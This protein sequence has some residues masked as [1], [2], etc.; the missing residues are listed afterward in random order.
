MKHK[1]AQTIASAALLLGASVAQAFTYVS[2]DANA[3]G[4]GYLGYVTVGATDTGG[5]SSN[6][7]A[8]SWEDQGIAPGGGEGWTHTSNWIAL[9][10]TADT[11]L[12]LTLA[13]DAS[14]AK[15][16]GGFYDV[17]NMFPSFTL[18]R[19]WDNN[20]MTAAAA[21]ALGY[22]P[23]TPPDDH[24]TY[25]NTGNVIWAENISYL[26]HTANSTLSSVSDSWF[27]SAG[28]YTLVFGSES[29]S[30][31]NPPKQ[32]YSASFSTSP[33]PEPSRVTFLAL[34]GLGLFAHRRR[35]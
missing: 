25:T 20:A 26:D 13:R 4:I 30:L 34:A 17:D 12:T 22:D 24:H 6:V 27:L 21:L 35:S 16:L 31:S 32:G 29:P 8:W 14:V 3:G 19:N 10:V 18:W 28:Q 23:L 9:D 7:G 1:I 33:V 2:G 5:F 15:P 11:W